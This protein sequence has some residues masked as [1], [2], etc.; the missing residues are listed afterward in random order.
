MAS[1]IAIAQSCVRELRNA[2]KRLAREASARAPE[3]RGDGE[4]QQC[5][6]VVDA[7]QQAQHRAADE[8]DLRH[9]IGGA[10]TRADTARDG[11]RALAPAAVDSRCELSTAS[12]GT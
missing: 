8:H 3:Q 12:S 9:R 10:H 4:E 6:L 11:D 7:L 5:L 2:D 1:T